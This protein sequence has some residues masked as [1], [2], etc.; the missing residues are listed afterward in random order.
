MTFRL[1]FQNPVT[2]NSSAIAVCYLIVYSRSSF[3]EQRLVDCF[4][5]KEKSKFNLITKKSGL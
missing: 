4:Q 3:V 5:G 1:I 2:N